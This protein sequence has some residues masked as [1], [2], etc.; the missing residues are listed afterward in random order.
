M[1][2]IYFRNNYPHTLWVAIMFYSAERC[3]AYGRWGTRGW[4]TI[5]YGMTKLVWVGNTLNS[6]YAYYAEASDGA[7]WTGQAGPVNVYHQAFDSCLNIRGSGSYASVGMRW[8]DV[9]NYD[10]YTMTLHPA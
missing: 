9:G 5:D 2:K 6:H 7:K 8:F 4:W 3:G 1:V 10:N